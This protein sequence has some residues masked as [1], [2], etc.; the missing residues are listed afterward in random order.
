MRRFIN[1]SMPTEGYAEVEKMGDRYAVRLEP[2]D[3]GDGSTSF[4]EC[5][6][7]GEPDME[8]LRADLQEWKAYRSG[9]DLEAVKKEKEAEILA[10]DSSPAVNSFE[11]RKGG[12]KVT[13]YWIDRDLRTSLEGDV[14]AC[15][16]VSD[17]Y[18][19][20]IREMGIT[21]ELNCN[22][23]LEALANLR[24][25]AYTAFNVTSQ[26][27]A[28]MKALET[29]EAVKGYDYTTG[30]PQKLSFDIENLL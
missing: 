27:I 26:H 23:F 13:D 9:R 7:D 12:E 3:N 4:Y 10:Y 2:V 6:T 1:A 21:L 22:K 25:Y 11:I 20:D 16:S 28:A 30:Y 14:I 24:R 18:K 15:S 29:Q 19:F 5:M 17:T 8:S